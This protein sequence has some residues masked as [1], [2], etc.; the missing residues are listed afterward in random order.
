MSNITGTIISDETLIKG[1]VT[2]E[3]VSVKGSIS[4]TSPIIKGTITPEIITSTTDLILT[5][6]VLA[7][8][9]ETNELSEEVGDTD[10]NFESEII[11]FLSF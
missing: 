6:R 5:A 9:I 2:S 4:V 11:T 3:D 8:E 10:Y 1:I 7:V